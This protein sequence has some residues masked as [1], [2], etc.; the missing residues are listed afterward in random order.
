MPNGWPTERPER[1]VD[2]KRI[3]QWVVPLGWVITCIAQHRLVVPRTWDTERSFDRAAHISWLAG[4]SELRKALGMGLSVAEYDAWALSLQDRIFCVGPDLKSLE[5]G[6]CAD[7][8]AR[9]DECR[10]AWDA[11]KCNEPLAAR[12]SVMT[13]SFSACLKKVS[14]PRHFGHY[15]TRC[16]FENDMADCSVR[17]F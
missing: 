16:S 11:G 2:K 15:R 8:H 10:D 7:P 9:W 12:C 13:A 14:L 3:T 1:E 4:N 6:I 5:C 17:S